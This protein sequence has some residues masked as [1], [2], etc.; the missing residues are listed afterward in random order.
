MAREWYI[1]GLLVVAMIFVGYALFREQP[2]PRIPEKTVEVERLR[3]VPSHY[4]DIQPDRV[5]VDNTR[6]NFEQI[7]IQYPYGKAV[8]RWNEY[9]K[10]LEPASGW[11]AALR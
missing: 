4:L 9:T 11:E 2:D 3:A 7:E 10:T 1:M 6:G 5:V 8:Y